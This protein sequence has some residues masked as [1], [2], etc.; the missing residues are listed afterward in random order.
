MLLRTLFFLS[1][2]LSH[3]AWAFPENVRHGYFSC[4][5]CHVSPSG[6]GVLTPY[7]RSLAAELMSTWGSTKTS[8]F[9]F[10]DNENENMNPSWLRANI[11][12]RAVQTYRNSSTME[13]AQFIPMEEDA[14]GGYDSEKFAIIAAFG[15]RAKDSSSIYHPNEF[16]S[17]RFYFLYRFDD[18][19]NARVGK[20]MFAFGLNGPDHI[21]ATR[22]GLG[23]NQGM[24]SYNL[25]VSYLGEKTAT[26]LTAISNAPEEKNI[27]KES[28][29]SATENFLLGE[30]SKLGLNFY[31]GEQSSS[32]RFVYGPSWIL[33]FTKNLY[34]YSEAFAQSQKNKDVGNIQN[35]Y[36]TFQR[37]N[38]ELIKGLTPFIQ[39]DRSYLDDSTR[40]SQLDSYGGGFRWLPY[41][42]FEITSFVGKEKSYGQT[43]SDFAWLMLN[44]Y[45]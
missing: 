21:T 29:F 12:L 25:E 33:S 35:G 8:G 43:A 22:R 39:F 4:T 17:R 6:G 31:S 45:L 19:W 42:H 11:F 5:A 26:I 27:L 20:F 24:E 7:G 10:S 41:P 28:G 16:F 37:L 38:Y 40:E 1:L 32:K 30:H 44:A 3:W 2:A 13:K 9:L 15:L 14:E 23:W 36:A 34:L 18:H